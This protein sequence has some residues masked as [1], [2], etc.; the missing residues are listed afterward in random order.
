MSKRSGGKILI[1][2]LRTQ[3]VDRI[4]GVPGESYLAAL[5]ALHDVGNAIQFVV[6]RQEG[7]AA[8]MAEAYA[9]LTGKPGICF[10]TRGPGA[11]NASVGVHTAFQDSSPMILLVGQVA[12]DTRE[13]EAFQEVE[14][15]QFFA[16]M[17]KGIIEIADAARIPEH[18]SHAFHLALSG[19]PGPVV[20]V[21]PEDMLTDEVEA[22]EVPAHRPVHASPSPGDLAT[23]RRMVSEAKRPVVIAGGGGWSA[24]A[25]RD[26]QDL[27][28]RMDLPV[29]TSFR[30]QDYLDNRHGNYVGDVGIGIHPALAKRIAEADLIVALGPRL[31]EATTQGYTLL[32][33]PVPRQTLIH[34]HAGAEELG[35][36]F[37]AQLAINSGLPNFLAQAAELEPIKSPAW[38][39]WRAEMRA[40]YLAGLNPRP[41]PGPVDM[42]EVIQELA[43]QVPQDSI[44]CNGAGNYTGWIHKIW[45]FGSYRTQLAPTSGTMG[46]GFPAAVA[47]KLTYPDRTVVA[48]AGDGCFLMTGQEMATAAL[49]KL[50]IIVLIVN[51]GIY[52]TILMHQERHYPGR[53]FGIELANPDF[54][55]LGAAYG[56]HAE[57]VTETAAFGPALA[58]A[59]ASKRLAVIELRVS[60]ESISTARTLSEI[61]QSAMR[62][63]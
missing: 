44:I 61:R 63:N 58:R 54:A 22:P 28:E 13:R 55:Q 6:C 57:L 16:P 7:G 5:D 1:D 31:G 38:A 8:F 43:R 23:F 45:R 26:L 35:R 15:K 39:K 53:P 4:F 10:V 41:Q 2:C 62:S 52:G 40:E 32:T 14:Y 49:Y 47:A 24:D 33:P 17:A 3:G 50:P 42:G 12:R 60:P 19:R 34:V 11:C 27:A 36:V 21:L 9:K 25:A 59:L 20:L 18:V 56:A 37:A 51:N 30:C 46:Y 48:V 29:T